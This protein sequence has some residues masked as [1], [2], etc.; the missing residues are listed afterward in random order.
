MHMPALAT[1]LAPMPA[2]SAPDSLG[3]YGR[4]AFD[5]MVVEAV[6]F[7]LKPGLRDADFLRIAQTTEAPLRGQAGFVG[8]QLVK[9][10]DDLWTDLVTWASLAQAHQAAAEMMKDPAFGPFMGMID[11]ATVQMT[12]SEI[13]WR[14]D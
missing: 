11:E 4:T 9:D 13:L 1:N 3:G 5:P 8:R 10:Q 7:R 2:R 14:M 12:H 6:R